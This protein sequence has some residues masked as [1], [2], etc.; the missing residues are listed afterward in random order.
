[1]TRKSAVEVQG[2]EYD[3]LACDAAGHVALFSTAGAGYAPPEFLA[4]VELL[5]AAISELLARPIS[6]EV[7]HVRAVAK[8]LPNTWG[9]VAKRG[10]FAFDSDPLGAPYSLV[11]R[12]VHPILVHELPAS[13]AA[14]VSRVRLESLQ[15][16]TA[17]TIPTSDLGG[18]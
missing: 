13:I 16:E 15:F 18:P 12:P 10:V 2:F 7:T 11:A 5:D 17:R 14:V 8:G 4:D 3:W 6:T 9:E 1:M